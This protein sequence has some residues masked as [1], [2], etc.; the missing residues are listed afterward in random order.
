MATAIRRATPK[1]APQAAEVFLA[2]R[3]TMTYLPHLHT[4]EE[5]RTFIRGV[6]E[7]KES[8]VAERDG[9]VVGFAVV[10]AGW[11]EHLYVQPSRFNSSTG[12][13]LFE[14]VCQEHPE[15]FQLWA[16]QQNTGARRFYERH[17]CALVR[18][19]NGADNEEKLPDALYVWPA[20]IVR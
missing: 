1:D 17:G 4:D 2:S 10:H 3:A 19:T 5:T 14:Q 12:T 11:L 6:V 18:L 9:T 8:W 7:N 16:F 13:R 15:G 20:K